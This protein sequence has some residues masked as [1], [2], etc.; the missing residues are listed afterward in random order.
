MKGENGMGGFF[1][2]DGPFY[3]IGNMLADIMILS[4]VWIL[5][6]LPV[7]TIGASTTAL[8]YVTTRR[9]SNKEGYLIRDFWKS[10]KTN[11]KQST[12]VWLAGLLIVAILLINIWNIDAVGDL[13]MVIL[14]FQICFLVE[15]SFISIYIYPLIAR[16]DMP[17]REMIRTAFFMGNKHIFTSLTCVVLA[18]AIILGSMMY[19][20][21]VLVA[22]G[23]YA[24]GASYFIMR[25][26]KKYRPEI[27]KEEI[28]EDG[29]A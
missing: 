12:I 22:M 14:P 27:D 6:S 4:L 5:F 28:I 13:K 10:F 25:V 21:L 2:L 11:F 19:P 29:W 17:F 20:L 18:G 9:I 16:F 23:L 3:R 26:F 1:S 24:F 8:F 15:L 7:V